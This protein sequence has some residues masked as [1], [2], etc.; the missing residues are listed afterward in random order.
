MDRLYIETMWNPQ[1]RFEAFKNVLHGGIQSTLLDEIAAWLVFTK[2]ATSGVTQKMQVHFHSP[3]FV[4][5]P[6][7]R[8]VGHLVNRKEKPAIKKAELFNSE[9]HLCDEADVDYY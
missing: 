4:N 1:K 2:C 5:V 6:H 7:I 9:N 8:L 3:V